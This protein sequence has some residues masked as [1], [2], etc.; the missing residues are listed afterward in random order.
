LGIF[1]SKKTFFSKKDKNVKQFKEVRT[2][3]EMSFNSNNLAIL[4][5]NQVE[6]VVG[7]KHSTIYDMVDRGTFPKPIHLTQRA[8]GW[9]S[10]EVQGWLNDRIAASRG[11]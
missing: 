10:H 7:L 3:K 9:L 6:K 5:L 8:V 2:N 11:I 1:L 4:R